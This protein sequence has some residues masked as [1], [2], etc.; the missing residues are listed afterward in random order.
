MSHFTSC[1]QLKCPVGCLGLPDQQR[2]VKRWWRSLF[3]LHFCACDRMLVCLAIKIV[4]KDRT[5]KS[6][7]RHAS[8]SLIGVSLLAPQ[9]LSLPRFA[10]SRDLVPSFPF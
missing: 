9:V 2:Y 8:F 6:L 3:F 10:R 4:S 5:E 7:P 1:V